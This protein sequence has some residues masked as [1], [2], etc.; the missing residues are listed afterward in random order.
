MSDTPEVTPVAPQPEPQVATPAPLPAQEAKSTSGLAIT[1]LVLGI[2]AIVLSFIPIINNLAFILGI[3][4]VVFGVIGLVA[5]GKRG[6]KKGHNIAVAGVVLTV[7][8]MV[9]TIAMQSAFSKAIYDATKETTSSAT[10]EST[11]EK[12]Q[13]SEADKSS[14]KAEESADGSVKIDNGNY[15]VKIVSAVK[16]NPDYEGKPTVLVTYEVTN[17]KN[18]NSNFMEIHTEVFQNGKSLNN[19]IYMDNPEG[20]DPN[21]AMTTLQPG[22]TNTVTQGYVLEDETN[23]VTV[24]V[25]GTIDFSS[26]DEAKKEFAL[27]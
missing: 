8:A 9:I 7:L 16:S 10:A 15:T 1:S 21:S 25:K 23:P 5:T 26:G 12:P 3:I 27:Q 18:K 13:K 19:A 14:E 6:K 2:I 17:N 20:Y 24:E 4:G 22:A 11:T